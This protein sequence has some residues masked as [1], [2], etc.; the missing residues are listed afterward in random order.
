MPVDYT[1][2]TN[3][4]TG[5][6]YN[7]QAEYDTQKAGKGAV[8][9]SAPAPLDANGTQLFPNGNKSY[10]GEGNNSGYN[11]G[12]SQTTYFNDPW[13]GLIYF[14]GAGS[15][16]PNGGNF[17]TN[18]QNGNDYVTHGSGYID[19]N[20]GEIVYGE[21]LN[22]RSSDSLNSGIIIDPTK[23]NMTPDAP[24]ATRSY[25]NATQDYG[26]GA[27]AVGIIPVQT[28]STGRPTAFYV[29]TYGG[30][31]KV[32]TDLDEAKAELAKY[33]PW[34]DAAHPAGT[35][36]STITAAP[37]ST[38]PS[39]VTGPSVSAPGEL[40]TPGAGENYYNATQGF[41]TQ[42]T[43]AQGT[44]DSTKGLYSQPTNAQKQFDAT[45]GQPTAAD[46]NWNG[47]S[48]KF[49]AP[50]AQE[51]QWNNYK[52]ALADPS[53][54]SSMYDRQQQ[55]TQVALDRRASSAGVGDSSAAAK[56][57]ANIGAVFGDRKVAA[58]QDF[59][60]TGMGLAGAS[61]QGAQG[62]ATTL[63]TL[64]TNKD[65]ADNNRINTGVNVDQGALSYLT[66]ANNAAG[67]ADAANL[68]RT[69]GGQT[70][71]TSAENTAIN[72]A[73]GGIDRSLAIGNDVGTLTAAG[74]READAT[75]LSVQMAAL[76]QQVASGNLTFE[77]AM[78]QA[79][80]TAA[81]M[82]V[83]SSATLQAMLYS[84]MTK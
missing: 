29:P 64:A 8:A 47:L 81:T 13:S 9:G 78:K 72:R 23:A 58:L 69:L 41:Y 65:T 21:G 2:M 40:S 5:K 54:L 53:A 63:G 30:G 16:N 24:G 82:G 84:K 3:P 73:N 39:A 56:A 46:Q 7:S 20:T 50:S 19:P 15:G 22:Q 83:V 42:P 12:G 6:P 36:G 1:Q 49:N 25:Y 77:A 57:T 18:R 11:F 80:E 35:P 52:S 66:Q 71:A 59:A 68:A 37:A 4:A 34:F 51:D 60:K 62:R 67:G 61:D 45:S 33:K 32:V 26:L 38:T 70:A 28:D 76:G 44:F 17:L 79:Q 27:D 10:A 31:G 43:N 75:T 74:L 14:G 55:Q 48:G